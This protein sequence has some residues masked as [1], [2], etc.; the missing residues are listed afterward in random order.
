MASPITT[1]RPVL[2][3]R[4]RSDPVLLDRVAERAHLDGVL[5]SVREGRSR[6]LVVHGEPGVGKTALLEQLGADAVGC[7]VERASGV[8]AEVE[9]AYAGVHQLCHPM[10]DHLA[11][12]PDTQRRALGT[13]F[14][15]QHGE[16]PDRF[17]VGLAVLNLLAE[18]AEERPLLCLV[19]DAHWLDRASA[20]TLSF[21]ARRL[22][23]EP[24]AL[25][26][27]ARDPLE[28]H[29]LADLPRLPVGGLPAED[30]RT[31]LKATLPVPLDD[32][33]RD[34]LIDESGGNPLALVELPRGLTAAELAGGFGLPAALPVSRQIEESFRRRIDAL[35]I[36]TRRLLLLAAT[37]P[38]GEG[39]LIWR[40]AARL[41]I[42]P[43]AAR[44]ALE[45]GLIRIDSDV[46]FTHP[47]VRSAIY[48]GS[49]S[50]QRRL[51][52]GA[53]SEAT[54]D[55]DRRAWHRSEATEDVD[56]SV[57]EELVS[58]AKR[59]RSRGGSAAAAA[60]LER[61][62][63]LS[64][65][66]RLR[67]GR[68]LAAAAAKRDAGA[69]DE[70]LGLIVLA[71]AGP[72]DPARDARAA[73]L[74][75][76]VRFLRGDS[77]GARTLLLRA[78]EDLEAIDVRA[79]RQTYFQALAMATWAGGPKETG[80][81][82]TARAAL[83]AL[84]GPGGAGPLDVLL[85]GFAKRIIDG[86]EQAVAPLRRGLRM[87]IET[88]DGSDEGTRWLWA[89]GNILGLFAL[90]LWDDAALFALVQ[91]QAER[92]HE[93]GALVRQQYA[94]SF[95]A[96]C[97]LLAGDVS[98]AAALLEEQR[99]IG[100][101]TGRT[102]FTYMELAVAALRDGARG[103]SNLDAARRD[104][105]V[106]GQYD[107][108]FAVDWVQAAADNGLGQHAE[109]ITCARRL[110]AHDRL[111]YGPVVLPVLLESAVKVGDRDLAERAMVWMSE[112]SELVGTDWARGIEAQGRAL[113]DGG[114]TAE[115][116]FLEAIDR[117]DRTRIAVQTARTRLL[118]GEW[119][120]RRRRRRDAREQ[121]R[122]AHEAFTA[123]GLRA[124]AE[125]ASQELLATGERARERTVE[126]SDELTPQE[127]TIARLA[128]EGLGNRAIAERLFISPRT[129]QYHLHKIFTKTGATSRAQLADVIPPLLPGSTDA[130][131][132]REGR[133]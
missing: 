7:R 63:I 43:A 111:S 119:L 19:D 32:R 106:R 81:L 60:F 132:R 52:H 87:V 28:D 38:T 47:L 10:I 99:M 75:G 58:A 24:V 50:E 22:A 70:A 133:R 103:A 31:L 41:G 96:T 78:A 112:R 74:R 57:A 8:Q 68:A 108:L 109:A 11:K 73:L 100:E 64:P 125:R 71:E 30:A 94:L 21:A 90:D 79:A 115:P 86:F 67:A 26:F 98:A 45:A 13:A 25:I 118:Y 5:E 91:R 92:A 9:L 84:P 76:L 83:A 127:A 20:Q 122:S 46:R 88:G 129:V 89:A 4:L 85:E 126:S 117:L 120:R 61:A 128:A 121:L 97:R 65:D 113:L 16:P 80:V 40:A 35:P 95:L 42:R 72:P 49:S 2:R 34:R 130:L 116:H 37:D 12:L 77:D 48:R 15:L 51:A 1:I 114:D 105:E 18:A 123:M 33:V 131:G 82:D 55:P 101:V 54:D 93:T 53:L 44:P 14:G 107:M 3:A 56:E 17:L 124:Y 104:A 59:A 39:L 6:T 62:S 66:P 36:D 29:E 27:G 69:L 23:V 110:F 102:E